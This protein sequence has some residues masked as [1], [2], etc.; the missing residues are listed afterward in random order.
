MSEPSKTSSVSGAVNP[1]NG[2]NVAPGVNSNIQFKS[3]EIGIAT[4]RHEDPFKEHKAQ[5]AKKKQ[6]MR[7]RIVIITGIVILLTVIGLIVW[8]AVFVLNRPKVSDGGFLQDETIQN[9]QTVASEIYNA[10]SENDDEGG[11][12]QKDLTGASEYYEDMKE[13]A[14]TDAERIQITISEMG[15]YAT[16][17][18]PELVVERGEQ[19]NFRELPTEEAMTYCGIMIN[20]WYS[21]GEGDKAQECQ[22][23]LTSESP[24]KGGGG[25]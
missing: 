18:E 22:E 17:S 21:L 15:F 5:S 7:K 25:S 12:G 14:E 24:E 4:A 3:S 23:F 13:T 1:A 20:A 10:G 6:K 19:I 8:W 16:Y 2:S 11:S 9:I